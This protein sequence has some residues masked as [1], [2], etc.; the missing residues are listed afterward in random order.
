MSRVT[1]C[2]IC[3]K[4]ATP[5]ANRFMVT[6]IG[7]RRAAM[8]RIKAC[9]PDC[10]EHDAHMALHDAIAD[11]DRAESAGDALQGRDVLMSGVEAFR[12]W[13]IERHGM[14]RMP[15]VWGIPRDDPRPT[16]TLRNRKAW[17]VVTRR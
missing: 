1:R 5:D 14:G 7:S 15:E 10:A 4:V 17:G 8:L 13:A 12:R 6:E 9:L 2:V 11:S 3:G 16:H